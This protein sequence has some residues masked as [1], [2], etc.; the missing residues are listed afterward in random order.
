[1]N[2]QEIIECLEGILFDDDSNESYHK[3]WSKVN[4]FRNMLKR[5]QLRLHVV[6]VSFY[7]G[8]HNGNVRCKEQCHGC[9]ED[10]KVN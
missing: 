4:D 10:E 9:E 6:G 5:K 3:S 8:G 2:E 1:M 7:C